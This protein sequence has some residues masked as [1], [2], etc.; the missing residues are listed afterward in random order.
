MTIAAN[1]IATRTELGQELG[2]LEINSSQATA[3]VD[4]MCAVQADIER[5]TLAHILRVREVLTPAQR[6]QYAKLINQQVCTA[7]PTGMH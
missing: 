2:K 7:C 3:C 1:A 4:R 5:A 6:E